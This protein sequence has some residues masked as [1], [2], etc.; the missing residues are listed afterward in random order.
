MTLTG[1]RNPFAPLLRYRTGDFAALAWHD[2]R[3]VLHELEGRQGVLFR[4]ADGRTVHS[5][6]ISRRLRRY[7]LSQF[8]LRQDAGGF[9]FRYRG[10]VDAD[11]LR[12]EL[13]ALLGPSASVSIDQFAEPLPRG[14]KVVQFS[15]GA[16]G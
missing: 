9:D 12:A 2:G 16:S 3:P 5:M 11:A 1:G 6:E 7:P 4:A 14:R 13:R 15:V 8:T 10:A